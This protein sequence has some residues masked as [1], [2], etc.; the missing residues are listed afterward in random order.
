MITRYNSCLVCHLSALSVNKTFRSSVESFL[1][2]Q[3]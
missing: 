3:G 1:F 2:K